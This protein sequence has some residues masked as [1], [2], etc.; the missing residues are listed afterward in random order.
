MDCKMKSMVILDTPL[1]E[2][3]SLIGTDYIYPVEKHELLLNSI[4]DEIKLIILPRGLE[5]KFRKKY[6]EKI[7]IGV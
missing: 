7:I 4:E 1:K 3:F 2:A 5:E 6:P